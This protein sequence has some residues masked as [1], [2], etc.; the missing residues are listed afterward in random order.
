MALNDIRDKF[1]LPILA[2]NGLLCWQC[3]E[4][5]QGGEKLAYCNRCKRAVLDCQRRNWDDE[6]RYLCGVFKSVNEGE[7]HELALSKVILSDNYNEDILVNQ[8]RAMSYRPFCATCLRTLFDEPH[9]T[10]QELDKCEYCH[11]TFFC[12]DTCRAATLEKHRQERC[13][14]LQQFGALECGKIQHIKEGGFLPIQTST[15]FPRTAPLLLQELHSWK[16]Y[17]LRCETANPFTSEVDNLESDRLIDLAPRTRWVAESLT[18][19]TEPS[20]FVL[21]TLAGLERSVPKLR[22]RKMLTLHVLGGVDVR[23][24]NSLPLSE[25][26]FHFLPKLNRLIIGF[27]GSEFVDKNQDLLEIPCCTSCNNAGRQL[28]HFHS[29]LPYDQFH[30][31]DPRATKHPPDM[32]INFNSFPADFETS[33][34]QDLEKALDL[35]KP[36]LFTSCTEGEALYESDFFD[37]LNAEFI[38]RPERNRWKSLVPE[39]DSIDKKCNIFYTNGWWYIIKGRSGKKSGTSPRKYTKWGEDS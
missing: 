24:A 27:V 29:P 13:W 12:S 11:L 2:V 30:K 16:D 25:D 39:M 15:D 7:Q 33:M 34:L 6:H 23:F 37:E 10:F 26:I 38:V 9:Q 17:F 35:E 1:D 14:E 28:Q 21:T 32:V 5:P 36:A 20:S 31:T 22:R 18:L 8:E 4:A 3:Y 19:A